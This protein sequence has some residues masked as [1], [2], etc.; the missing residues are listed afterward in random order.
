MRRGL[1]LR[2]FLPAL[3]AV[4]IS[5]SSFGLA[6]P[7]NAQTSADKAT[8]RQLGLEGEDALNKKDYKTAEDKFKRADALYHALTLTLGLARAQAANGKLVAAQESYNRVLHE[9]APAGSPPAFVRAVDD[10][11]KE[12]DA[13][14][15]QVAQVVVSVT[16]SDDP[17][18]TLDDTPFPNAAL[19]VKRPVDP[20]NHVVKATAKG[21]KPGEAHFT[22]APAGEGTASIAL[23]ADPNAIVAQQPAGANHTEPPPVAPSSKPIN[24]TIGY[25]AL[26]V[27]AAGVVVGGIFGALALGAHG[28]LNDECPNGN[29]PASKQD[30]ISSYHTKGTV[31]TIGFIV[32][33]VGLAAGAVLILT[34]PKTHTEANIESKNNA[35][36]RQA[37]IS[38]Y[39]GAGT[40]GVLGSF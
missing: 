23:E 34:A 15:A 27:G 10:A 28:S 18:V 32:G 30:D 1:Q 5:T 7:A 40:A 24:K 16:G 21:Y 31:S 3:L 14:S 12:V 11:R 25:A 9:G 4:A 37:F 39:V 38:P 8:A 2:S 13:V 35:A 33:G 26:G 6:L 19:G 22:V 29:C 36:T 20:G 17:T